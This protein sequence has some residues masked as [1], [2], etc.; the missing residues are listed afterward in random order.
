MKNQS[1]FTHPQL[2]AN[3]Y[4]FLSSAENKGIYFEGQLEPN[5]CLAPF[6]SIVE[7]STKY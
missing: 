5:S 3:L 7:T 6:T 1:S 4:E 2:V